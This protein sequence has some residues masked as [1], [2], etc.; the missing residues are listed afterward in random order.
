MEANHETLTGAPGERFAQ[1]ASFE[2]S[3]SPRRR[4]AS[5]AGRR[6]DRT[7]RAAARR[8]QPNSPPPA[9]KQL[10]HGLV[11]EL[12]QNFGVDATAFA[13][14]PV[15]EDCLYLNVWTP[16]LG[17]RARLPVMVWI[18]GG[19]NESGWSS[20]PTTW[21][22]SR[23]PRRRGGGDDRIPLGHI[24]ILRPSATSQDRRR[25][26]ISGCSIRSRRCAG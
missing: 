20:S 3:R 26:A 11:S 8:M 17:A 2:G 19:A 9:I 14:P 18:H 22:S 16:A 23:S 13:D 7:R 21:R 15:S 25:R 4:W 5:C 1:V 10:Q 24:R 12:A 6:R